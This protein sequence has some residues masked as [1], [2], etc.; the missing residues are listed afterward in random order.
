ME[1][2]MSPHRRALGRSRRY[3]SAAAT[4]IATVGLS[5]GA[6]ACTAGSSGSPDTLNIVLPAEPPTLD[7]CMNSQTSTGIVTRGNIT[8]G[9]TFRDPINSEVKPLL[10]TQWQQTDPLTWTFTLRDGVT[11]HDGSPMNADS[12]VASIKRT[13]DPKLSC[14]VAGQFF[15]E[16]TPTATAVNPTTVQIRT[17]VPDP[18]LPLRISFIGITPANTDPAERV[19]QPIGTGPYRIAR[20]NAGTDLS[21]EQYGQYWG[22]KPSFPKARYVWRSEDSVRANMV[23]NGEADVATFLSANQKD[24]QGAVTFQTNQVAYLRTDPTQA[25]MSDLRVR[26]AIDYA[27]DRDSLLATVFGGVGEPASQIVPPG[28][29]GHDDALK[30]TPYDPD[31]AKT[32]VAEAKADGVPVD[33]PITFI[34]RNDIYP[35]AS[36]AAEVVQAQLQEIGLKVDIKMLDVNNWLQYALR[37]FVPNM[38]PTLLQGQHGNQGGD[39]SFTMA[40][41]YGSQGHQSTYG[42][43]ELDALIT[44]A[45]QQT[46]EVRQDAFAAALDLQ[47]EIVRDVVL[48]DVGGVMSLSPKVSYKPDIAAQDEMR[49]ADMRRGGGGQ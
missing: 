46:G 22:D 33:A 4:V 39:A 36:Q 7:P 12:V 23:Q 27:I 9:L 43:T 15:A 14:D 32:L 17:T 8:E 25:P 18:I 19:R 24:A 34:G 48:I 35:R 38:G 31:K 6:T 10:A 37:P 5:L 3:A 47:H 41:N 45:E 30:P 16:V 40:N 26:Q 49:L 42:T 28:F 1:N 2:P 13:L 29:I 20:W 11:F 21:L 44:G